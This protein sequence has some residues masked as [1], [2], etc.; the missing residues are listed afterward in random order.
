MNKKNEYIL[1]RELEQILSIIDDKILIFGH[2]SKLL[3]ISNRWF[4]NF[5]Y[6]NV[7]RFKI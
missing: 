2:S 3:W 7:N 6:A 5:L 1:E 4:L